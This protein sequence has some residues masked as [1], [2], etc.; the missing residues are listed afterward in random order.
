MSAGGFSMDLS[1]IIPAFNEAQRLPQTLQAI[2]EYLTTDQRTVEIIVVDDGST[3]HTRELA[4]HQALTVRVISHG[5]NL[6]KG[7]A[8]RTGMLAARGQWRYLCDADLSTPITELAKFWAQREHFDVI[9]GSRRLPGARIEKSQTWWKESL[10]QLGNALIRMVVA[11]GLHDTRCGFK[12]FHHRTNV[13]FQCQRINGWTYDDEIIYLA[14]KFG[15][16]LTEVPVR[17]INDTRTKVKFIDYFTT[18]ID[19]GRIKIN[20][21]RGSYQVPHQFLN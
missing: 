6:G 1:I 21:W 17:W 7:A 15:F 14:R 16:R 18:L 3:D 2:A 10:G 4:T 20:D 8:V 9:I 12:L 11:P 19:L 13:L 5:R